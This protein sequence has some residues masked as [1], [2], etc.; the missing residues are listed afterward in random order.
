MLRKI[1]L[2]FLGLVALVLVLG[3]GGRCYLGRSVPDPDRGGTIAGLQAPVEVWRDSLGVPHLWA[4]GEADLFRAMGYVHAQDRLFQME[5]F[6]RVADGRLAELLGEQ[7]VDSDKFLRTVGMG[8][9]A[10]DNERRL[11]PEQRA[12]LQAYADG[13]NAWI[14]DH[15]G[16]LPPEFVTLRG[17]P[18]PWTVRNTLSIAKIMA[19]DLAD[20]EI[21]LQV[22]QAVDRVGPELARD[23]FPAYPDSGATI[24]GAD[25]EWK[26][27]GAQPPPAAP[28]A[29]VPGLAPTP[30][31]SG[32]VPMPKVPAQVLALLDG[33]SISRASNAWVIGG[34]RTRSGKPILANDMHLA[35]RTP[36]IWYLAALHGGA[37]N[38]T[39]MT[40]PGVPV[41]VAGHSDRVAWGYTNAMVDD[42]D[43]FVE[44]VDAA[45]ARRYRTPD[46]WAEMVMRP[47]TIRVKG[48]KQPVVHTVRATR[49][50]PVISDVEDRAGSRVL[51]MRW[52][53]AEPSTEVGALLAMNQARNAAE[54]AAA[55]RGFDN[56]HQN[57]V[58]ADA[59]GRIGYW[60]VGRVP[61]RRGGDGVLPVP[62][63]TGEG[64]WVRFLDF[65]EHPHALSPADGFVV[66][67]NNRQVGPAYPFHITRN[68][69]DP[70]R[71]QRIRQMVEAGRGLTA[72]DV[73]RQ[74]MDVVDLFALRH[75]DRAAAAADRAGQP[76]AAAELRRWN[77]EARVDSRGAA[78]FYTWFEQL[79]TLV[80]SDEF[81]GGTVYFPRSTLD[82][83]LLQGGG[84]W[85]DNVRTPDR[86]ETLAELEADAMRAAS[87]LASGKT[88]GEL[89]VTRIDHPLGSVAVL[90]R[91]MNLNIGPFPSPGAPN[92]V[93][94]A[95]FSART[96]PFVT[97]Y[98]PSQRHVV[99][100]A[101]VDGA[102]GFVVPTGQS[103]IPFSRHYRDQNELW[104][105]GR[106]WRIPLDRR[107][108][109]ARTVSRMTLKP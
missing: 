50:G 70:Y 39:G 108:A 69:A 2:A 105:T 28:A 76:D 95:G 37:M 61:V 22:Q 38:V 12:L 16:P 54:F 41:V 29:P 79:R 7:L 53:A 46:G 103:G 99:D 66:T 93:N 89:H 31:V 86:V 92:T 74:Q 59:D 35:L 56:P 57:V 101:D 102:G 20:W 91:A 80:G 62:G 13:V 98:G 23:L 47:E 11:T 104:R 60:M 87:Q 44:Q 107:Q 32:P 18:E 49:N 52:T 58:F 73:A 14:R 40:L 100:L 27:R 97:A 109:Q 106:L 45:N 77:G 90:D 8:R 42:V 63:W 5:M 10:A 88:W 75:R 19:W 82:R 6:R 33:V 3:F 96:P 34:Q 81:G 85:A 36:A 24:L 21:G 67:A 4:R 15:P 30:P 72:A 94:V 9:A 68:W 83:V 78:L 51:A 26:G 43:F 17:R 84:R 65:D 48:K 55:L 64:E 25:A 1:G 71:A